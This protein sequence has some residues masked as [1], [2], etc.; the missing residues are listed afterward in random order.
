MLP[1]NQKQHC[2]VAQHICDTLVKVIFIYISQTPKYIEKVNPTRLVVEISVSKQIIPPIIV[3]IQNI[4]L[5][6]DQSVLN[7]YKSLLNCCRNRLVSQL[8]VL[9]R[10]SKQGASVKVSPGDKRTACLGH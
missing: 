5:N 1:E 3:P 8:V 10:S 4:P 2:Q 9:F 6:H 7:P